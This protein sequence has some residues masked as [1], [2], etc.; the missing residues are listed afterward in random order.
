MIRLIIWIEYSIGL[1]R[2]ISSTRKILKRRDL[3]REYENLAEIC[4]LTNLDK[5]YLKVSVTMRA[6]TGIMLLIGSK[7]PTSRVEFL[8]EE[9]EF[10]YKVNIIEREEGYRIEGIKDIPSFW[11]LNCPRN[12]KRLM[13]LFAICL[14]LDEKKIR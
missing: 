14:K 7:I 12:Y 3:V 6:K 2:N 1:W 10:Y 13:E 8:K 9:V 4:Y 5:E 11:F